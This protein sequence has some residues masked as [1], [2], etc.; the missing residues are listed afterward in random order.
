MAGGP[1]LK[2]EIQA[3]SKI[4][5]RP[6][7][8]FVGIIGGAKVSDKIKTI[9]K[10]LVTVDSL[11][12]G[13]AMAYP[14]LKAKGHQIG[15]SLCSDED[16]KLA[17]SLLAEDKAGKI[18]LPIDHIVSESLEGPADT[19]NAI[20]IPEGKMGLDIGPATLETVL[21]P[22]LSTA[23]TVFWNGPMGLFEK[24]E[25]ANGTMEVARL[26][27][28]SNAFSLDGGGDSVSAVKNRDRVNSF[29]MSRQVAGPR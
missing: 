19:C 5:D 18:K 15:S 24:A 16:V 17:K 12:I 1:L 20:D 21:A 22:V 23:K 6:E 2:R 3:L 29:H 28:R 27:A 11:L 7:K 8:P 26:I 4:S 13:G 9:E 10:L 14:F 25:F